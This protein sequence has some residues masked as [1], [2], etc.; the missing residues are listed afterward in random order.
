[1]FLQELTQLRFTSSLAISALPVLEATR[2]LPEAT[3]IAEA[4]LEATVHAP[5]PERKRVCSQT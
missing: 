5:P 1:M 4:E 2:L 3:K